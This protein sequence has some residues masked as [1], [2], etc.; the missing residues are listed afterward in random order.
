MRKICFGL[1]GVFF[2]L[3]LIGCGGG[4]AEVAAEIEA[5]ESRWQ[6]Q[7]VTDYEIEVQRQRGVEPAQFVTLEVVGGEIAESYQD[8]TPT[9]GSNAGCVIERVDPEAFTVEGLFAYAR[10]NN[11]RASVMTFDEETGVLAFLSLQD[12]TV[13]RVTF[14]PDS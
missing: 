2:L 7:G 13:V 11:Y 1:I 8:C 14:T 3:G 4:D 12:E 10:D 5:A 6:A 9:P